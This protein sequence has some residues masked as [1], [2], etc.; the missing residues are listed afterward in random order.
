MYL[1]I[2]HYANL[3]LEGSTHYTQS[4]QDT[5]EN[6]MSFNSD[7]FDRAVAHETITAV[8]PLITFSRK[9]QLRLN[10]FDSPCQTPT[11]TPLHTRQPL[12]KVGIG[13]AT[14]FKNTRLLSTLHNR[15][16]NNMKKQQTMNNHHH[17]IKNGNNTNNDASFSFDL[18][19]STEVFQTVGKAGGV[20][21]IGSVGDT[22][23]GNSS[24][25]FVLPSSLSSTPVRSST[26]LSS[27][28]KPTTSTFFQN[29]TEWKSVGEDMSL[30]NFNLSAEVSALGMAGELSSS[31]T[32][33]FDVDERDIEEQNK[34]TIDVE[35][36]LSVDL[37]KVQH[38]CTFSP[39]PEVS[40]DESEYEE[41]EDDD[42]DED[43]IVFGSRV[44]TVSA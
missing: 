25:S 22:S 13:R 19:S 42:E 17:S 24:S 36:G 4:P 11:I 33:F 10:C 44:Q 38:S 3:T 16:I 27:R 2:T 39:L 20:E 6:D 26:P 28:A 1:S 29:S 21:G 37:L 32:S 40:E 23:K 14:G 30:H 34:D 7:Y 18:D 12:K 5:K 8:T 31:S 41:E 15:S 43:E 35:E 9:H